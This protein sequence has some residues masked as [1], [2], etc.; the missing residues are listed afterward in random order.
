MQYEVISSE[1]VGSPVTNADGLT[2]TWQFNVTS[3]VVGNTYPEFYHTDTSQF[4]FSVMDSQIVI[5]QKLDAAAALYVQTNY[6][7]T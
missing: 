2:R 7:N 3:N 6:P 5:Q 4:V 1:V